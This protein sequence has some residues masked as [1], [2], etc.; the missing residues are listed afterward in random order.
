MMG[1]G[2]SNQPHLETM[3]SCH[4]FDF[5]CVII[6]DEEVTLQ[7]LTDPKQFLMINLTILVESLASFFPACCIGRVDEI[8]NVLLQSEFLHHLQ[9]VLT[10]EVYTICNKIQIEKPFSQGEWIPTGV[11][12]FPVLPVLQESR[13]FSQYAAVEGSILQYCLK[14]SML[15]V[16]GN[17][18][19]RCNHRFF[20]Q[21]E[22]YDLVS[23]PFGVTVDHTLP[24]RGNI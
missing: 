11:N 10:A 22:F 1:V 2:H 20:C 15:E 16:S 17:L 9:S 19:D 5:F 12:A 23:K 4:L 14:R 24:Y 13:P 21:I 18:A 3:S 6:R 7:R 8:D